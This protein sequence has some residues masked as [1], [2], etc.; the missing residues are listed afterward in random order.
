[1]QDGKMSKTRKGDREIISVSLPIALYDAMEEICDHFN[2]NRSAMIANAIARYL[3]N[4]GK[5]VG[6]R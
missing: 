2:M 1:M 6:E 3:E 4:L 5:R